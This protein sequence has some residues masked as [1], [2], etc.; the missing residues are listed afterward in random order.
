MIITRQETFDN[1]R[2]EIDEKSSSLHSFFN[3]ISQD[4]KQLQKMQQDNQNSR[5]NLDRQK[6]DDDAIMNDVDAD[7]IEMK[8]ELAILREKRRLAH[9]RQKF[10]QI[11][12]DKT[13]RFLVVTLS[14]RSRQE[15]EL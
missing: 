7:E 8:H 5:E 3:F 10:E 6:I 2:N 9:L 14:I 11:R 12:I 4:T 15:N 13:L 1:I